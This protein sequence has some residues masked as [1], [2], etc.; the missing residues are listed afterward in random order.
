MLVIEPE[1]LGTQ[2]F[3]AKVTPKISQ[4]KIFVIDSLFPWT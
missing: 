4:K 2:I 3:L 1:L